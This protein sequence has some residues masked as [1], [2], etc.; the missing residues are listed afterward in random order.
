VTAALPPPRRR[1]LAVACLLAI[2]VLLSGLSGVG[3]AADGR[4]TGLPGV[5]E[6]EARF[7]RLATLPAY[8]N[9]SPDDVASAEIAAATRDGRTLV[10]TD[11]PGERLGL[12]ELD[13]L[14]RPRPAGTVALPGEPTSVDVLGH[15]ALTVVDTSAS[16]TDPSGVLQVV[17]LRSRQVVASHDLGG[18]PDSIDL[19]P[20]GRYAAVAIENERDEDV[21]DGQLPQLP[22]GYLAVV[23][24]VG[25]PQAWTVRRVELTGLAAV[26]PEDPEPEY[27]SVNRRNQAVVTLQEN[28]HLAVVDLAEGEVV[29]HFPAG[30]ATV[31]G[32]DTVEDS[33][34][35]LDGTVTAAREP[36]GVA[37]VDDRHVATADEGDLQGGSRTLTVFDSRTGAVVF[38]SGAELERLAVRYGQYPEFR[39]EDRGVEPEGL[40]VATYHGVRYAFVGMERATWS[41]STASATRATPSWSRHCPPASG[42]RACCHCPSAT[43]WPSPPRR[44]PPPTRSAPRSRPTG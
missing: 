13:R 42:P 41:R 3:T 6:R 40:A 14:D 24:L 7:Q 33:Q 16:F 44:T 1:Q 4:G 26:A 27:V 31:E 11:S 20:D 38:S 32:V 10:Y 23:D 8:A 21:N 34:I 36:D 37:W 5:P 17:D 15:L 25:R 9:S 28:N 22:G 19:S 35:R 18:Q 29:S 2:G 30:Q 43:R 12:V 39:A